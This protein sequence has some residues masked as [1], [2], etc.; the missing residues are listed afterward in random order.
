MNNNKYFEN[1]FS[2][3]IENIKNKQNEILKEIGLNVLKEAKKVGQTFSVTQNFNAIE[4]ENNTSHWLHDIFQA[5]LE[6]LKDE[7]SISINKEIEKLYNYE[8]T[9]SN[10]YFKEEDLLKAIEEMKKI[11]T[12]PIKEILVTQF[13]MP[14]QVNIL[15]NKYMC[16]N[17][18]VYEEFIKTDPANGQCYFLNSYAG[19]PIFEGEEADRRFKLYFEEGIRLMEGGTYE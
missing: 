11:K 8:C 9:C 13:I 14:G 17:K 7:M 5:E 6:K 3:E 19:I 16:M 1:M 2:E 12:N 10:N 4:L 18:D 15:F